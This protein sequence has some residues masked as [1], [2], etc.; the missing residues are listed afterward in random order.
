MAFNK[1][2]HG[3]A[4]LTVLISILLI[5]AGAIVTSTGSGDAVP[6][7][8]LSYGSL[9]PP[10]VGGIFYE[11]THRLIAGLTG[12]LITILT[13]WIW[14]KDPRRKVRWVSMSA[15]LAVTFQ[16][17]LGGLRVLVVSTETIQDAAIQLTGISRLETIRISVAVLHSF[18]AQT[19]VCLLIVIVIFTS[20]SW[21]SLK[22]KSSEQ[23]APGKEWLV[24]ISLI[25]FVFLQLVIGAIIRHT[26]AGLIIPDFPLSFGKII[27]PFGDL[28]NDPSLPF[29]MTDNEIYFKVFIQFSHRVLAL[30]ILGNV[31]YLFLLGRTASHFKKLISLL[32]IF[33]IA[34]IGLGALNIWTAKSLIFTVFHVVVGTLILLSSLAIFIWNWRYR[35]YYVETK[36]EQRKN[37][38]D[39]LSLEDSVIVEM[40]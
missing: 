40:E 2:L 3:F 20:K 21:F 31:V 1:W 4:I 30:I 35:K 8:P 13:L 36:L 16:A 37:D 25:L 24:T 15:F 14:R 28:P 9:T 32:L 27:P 6:D 17:V 5:V 29:P 34:Q 26:N 7:W 18:L 33:T 11:H 23:E 19:V 10:M 38:S 39:P 12:I 22:I